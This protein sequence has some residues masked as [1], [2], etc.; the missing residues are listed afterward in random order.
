[1]AAEKTEAFIIPK[2]TLVKLNTGVWHLSP[3]PI[4]ERVLHLMIIMPE[5]VYGNDCVVCDFPEAEHL[6][7]VL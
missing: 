6:E 1:M 4:H 7:I 5:R 3:Y 2:G